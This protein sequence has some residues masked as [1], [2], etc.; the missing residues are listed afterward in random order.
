[1]FQKAVKSERSDMVFKAFK[2]PVIWG[3]VCFLLLYPTFPTELNVWWEALQQWDIPVWQ[4]NS[5]VVI[6]YTASSHTAG[7]YVNV[8]G[9][10][11]AMQQKLYY[12]NTFCRMADWTKC[13]CGNTVGYYF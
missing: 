1:M 11:A 7:N 8:T 10:Q 3:V 9:A 2:A 13:P 6:R 5:N 12:Y 4:Q